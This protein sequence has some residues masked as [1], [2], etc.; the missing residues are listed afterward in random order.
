VV[1]RDVSTDVYPNDVRAFMRESNRV[2]SALTARNPG[3]KGDL[4]V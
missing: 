4:A 3:D 2:A 1:R